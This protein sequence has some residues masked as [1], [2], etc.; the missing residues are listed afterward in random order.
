MVAQRLIRV[1]CKDCK[2]PYTPDKSTLESIGITP[3][4]FH[5]ATIYKAEGCESCFHTGYKGRTGIFEI[6]LLD[7]SLKSLILTDP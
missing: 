2:Q 4:Q 3:D 5:E 1:L 6:M 7:S